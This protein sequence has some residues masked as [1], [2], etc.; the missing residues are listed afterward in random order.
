L[1]TSESACLIPEDEWIRLYHCI[2]A[3]WELCKKGFYLTA[4]SL[5]LMIGPHDHDVVNGTDV[6]GLKRSIANPL[7]GEIVDDPLTWMGGCTCK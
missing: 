1:V 7:C 2:V 5:M 3:K 4:A 6:G